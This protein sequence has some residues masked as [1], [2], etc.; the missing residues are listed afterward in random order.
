MTKK[1]S[2][3]E[4]F[5]EFYSPLCNYAS[6]L[7]GD[8]AMAEE[9]VQDLFV[10]LLERNSLN[11]VDQLDRY[12]IRSV[13]FRCIDHLRHQQK[14]NPIRIDQKHEDIAD[15]THASDEE[16]DALFHY[17]VAKLPPKTRTVF[18]LVRQSEMTY[19]E[20]AEELNI[21]VKTVEA[22]MSRALQKLRIYL[23][24]YGYLSCA[25]FTLFIK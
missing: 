3:E 25:Y 6:R 21:S 1:Q 12:L 20:V 7:V 18:L 17:L 8:D 11:R 14:E 24:D 23:K 2:Y 22:Q 19:Q 4:I 16:M 10:H 5:H 15:V 9:I 13:K